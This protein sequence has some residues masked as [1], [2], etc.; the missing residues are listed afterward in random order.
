[1]AASVL[2]F[3]HKKNVSI[4]ERKSKKHLK[5]RACQKYY[6]KKWYKGTLPKVIIMEFYFEILINTTKNI[7][8]SIDN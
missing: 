2:A 4:D 5:T 1:M 6:G 7:K 3:I 8:K